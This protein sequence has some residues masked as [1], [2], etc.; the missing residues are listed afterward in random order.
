[1]DVAVR[2]QQIEE[3]ER[4]LAEL[5]EQQQQL[6]DMQ[7]RM[8]E[9]LDAAR[10]AQRV[11][12]LEDE[13]INLDNGQ[14]GE[15]EIIQEAEIPKSVQLERDAEALR[16]K[17]G[18]LKTKKSHV[19]H[20]VAEIQAFEALEQA[21][22][23]SV[24]VKSKEICIS[25]YLKYFSQPKQ[26]LSKFFVTDMIISVKKSVKNLKND[27]IIQITSFQ[28][29]AF[30]TYVEKLTFLFEEAIKVFLRKKT[31]KKV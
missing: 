8:K 27:I 29:S 21:S 3:S 20:L 16:N 1:M 6:D 22:C 30:F 4:K 12:L 7:N 14:A 24:F 15:E 2:K 19:D 18:Q 17:L 31:R 25:F 11:L 13:G 5:Q 26:F 23:V 10:E 9:R 28:A